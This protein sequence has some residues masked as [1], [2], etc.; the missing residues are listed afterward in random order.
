MIDLQP[1]SIGSP[2]DIVSKGKIDFAG[3]VDMSPGIEHDIAA[4]HAIEEVVNK[5]I[6]KELMVEQFQ[7]AY[8]WKTVRGMVADIRKRWKDDVILA[9]NVI[10]HAYELF[11]R[12]RPNAQVRFL[13]HMKLAKY[14]KLS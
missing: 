8:Y 10:Q 5:E 12:H 4:D 3:M 13:L 11:K 2:L 7:L 1:L 14:E 6:Y 9:E